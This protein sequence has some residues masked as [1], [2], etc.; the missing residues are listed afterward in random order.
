MTGRKVHG[1]QIARHLLQ[2]SLFLRLL[3]IEFLQL[4]VKAPALF[5]S[6]FQFQPFFLQLIPH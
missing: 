6:L 4:C 5:S 2:F 1:L 3:A